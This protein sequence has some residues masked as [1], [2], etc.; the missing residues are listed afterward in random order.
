MKNTMRKAKVGQR[1]KVGFNEV[2]PEVR[3]AFC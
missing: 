2:G 1:D 3:A